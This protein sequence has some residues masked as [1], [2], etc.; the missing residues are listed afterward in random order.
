MRKA[1]RI[2]IAQAISGLEYLPH[3]TPQMAFTGGSER[4]FAKLSEYRD[5]AVYVGFYSGDSE[6]ERHPIGDEI[7]LVL[8]GSTT[9]IVRSNGEDRPTSLM[10]DD[11]FVVPA[12]TWHRFSGSSKLKVMTITPQPTDHHLNAPKA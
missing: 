5:G 4:A 9:V 2:P 12:N 8:D 3:R 7:V 1:T 11:L 6:W 10:R